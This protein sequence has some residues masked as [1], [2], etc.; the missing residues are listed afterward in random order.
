MNRQKFSM[1]K[2]WVDIGG[3]I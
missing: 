2:E 1:L 3:G